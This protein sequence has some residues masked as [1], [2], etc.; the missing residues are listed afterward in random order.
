MGSLYRY[1]ALITKLR[2]KQSRLL[3]E[4]Q[5]IALASCGSL[6]ELFREL[7]QFPRYASVFQDE[8]PESISRDALERK[9]MTHQ[10]QDFSSLYLFAD[11]EQRAFFKL[12]ILRYESFLLK[13]FLR[14]L[15]GGIQNFD[16]RSFDSFFKKHGGI[17]FSALSSANSIA[18]AAVLLQKSRY[19]P[20]FQQLA[21]RD[22]VSLYDCELA[23]DLYSFEL[24]RK[25][26]E[27]TLKREE[28]KVFLALLE[29]TI[30]LLNFQ[31]I[32]RAKKY[33]NMEPS[34][35]SA[36][37]IPAKGLRQQAEISAWLE[38]DS[39]ED[40]ISFLRRGPWKPFFP[41]HAPETLEI[42]P[43]IQSMLTYY[44]TTLAKQT[45]Y[46]CAPI[47][48]Y[49]HAQELEVQ[50]LISITEAI[51]YGLSAER[52]LTAILQLKD[53]RTFA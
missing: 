16:S 5:L 10:F 8:N 37:L 43:I 12:E 44:E 22:Q 3:S 41:R 46:S 18:E 47:I 6:P 11:R 24:L 28:K 34:K 14:S 19:A 25:Q 53:R 30:S 9:L 7:G 50:R 27:K 49:L 17:D 51:R 20:L 40:Y 15:F 2:A 48:A 45:P 1:S 21:A 35:I 42:E 33:Y 39:E 23:L 31:W 4:G 36:L 38:A 32:R 26:A 52:I 13:R 29:Q